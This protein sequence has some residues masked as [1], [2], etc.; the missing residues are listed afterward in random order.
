MSSIFPKNT[1][2][3]PITEKVVAIRRKPKNPNDKRIKE[4]PEN[5][6]VYYLPL[7]KNVVELLEL[8][9]DSWVTAIVAKVADKKEVEDQ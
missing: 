3:F 9:P 8:N 6:A 5:F 1:R 2:R 4:R 7:R